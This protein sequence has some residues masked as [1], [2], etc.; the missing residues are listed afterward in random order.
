MNNEPNRLPWLLF[1]FR[2]MGETQSVAMQI[3]WRKVSERQVF[4]FQTLPL[5][6]ANSAPNEE[7]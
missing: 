2:M 6:C 1:L 7:S 5:A 4:V 3:R